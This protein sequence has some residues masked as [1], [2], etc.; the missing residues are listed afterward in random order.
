MRPHSCLLGMNCR[1]IRASHR[2]QILWRPTKSIVCKGNI[3]KRGSSWWRLLTHWTFTL[4][5]ILAASAIPG[6]SDP[7]YAKNGQRDPAKSLP[8]LVR[9]VAGSQPRSQGARH[10]HLRRVQ[11]SAWPAVIDVISLRCSSVESRVASFLGSPL[12]PKSPG[13]DLL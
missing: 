3:W 2:K 9:R 8:L 5:A 1:P 11:G 7:R 12:G 13:C 10:H 6:G 4:P